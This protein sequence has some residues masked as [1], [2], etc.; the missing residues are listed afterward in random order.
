MRTKIFLLRILSLL[1]FVVLIAACKK[2]KKPRIN[3]DEQPPAAGTRD[4][5]TRDSIFLYAKQTFLW[6]DQLPTYKAFQPR[7][8]NSVKNELFD[9]TQ[10]PVNPLT[11][12]PY[13]FTGQSAPKYSYIIDNINPNGIISSVS[14][15]GE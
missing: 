5:L 13:E 11:G 2:D 1:F 10:I 7:Q 12:R 9:I 4:E 6:N 8:Y 14:L 15:E 3:P